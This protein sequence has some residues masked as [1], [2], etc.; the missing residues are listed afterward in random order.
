MAV[1]L[2]LPV[3]LRGKTQP[4]AS[5]SRDQEKVVWLLSNIPLLSGGMREPWAELPPLI[6]ADGSCPKQI[7]DAIWT[8]QSFWQPFGGCKVIDGVVDPKGSTLGKMNE[9]VTRVNPSPKPPGRGGGPVL[10]PVEPQ[11]WTIV[12]ELKYAPVPGLPN[13]PLE[14]GQKAVSFKIEGMRITV[15][16]DLDEP[17][18]LLFLGGGVG[19]SLDMKLL[20]KPPAGLKTNPWMEQ[21]NKV[22]QDILN[23]G[24]K[25]INSLIPVPK[26]AASTIL[27][28]VNQK[29]P[30]TVGVLASGL[31]ITLV[32]DSSVLPGLGMPS[33][34]VAVYFFGC[35]TGAVMAA[36]GVVGLAF[37]PAL[38]PAAF[39]AA[40]ATARAIGFSASYTPINVLPGASVTLLFGKVARVV[41]A[42]EL[43]NAKAPVG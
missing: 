24:L 26:L 8:F 20:F 35:N 31:M 38:L 36:T 6:G 28:T 42:S 41:P 32:C 12:K 27:P 39:S 34:K 15:R 11:K 16:K 23:N 43:L 14:I 30:L 21:V 25:L 2:D 1:Q 3:G 19:W 18:H 40:T 4:V 13:T 5:K 33:G 17:M 22:A 9:L 7:A 37:P 29:E 10:P